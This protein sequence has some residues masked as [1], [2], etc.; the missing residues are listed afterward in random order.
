[1]KKQIVDFL[2]EFEISFNLNFSRI[3]CL[4][5]FKFQFLE[6]LT[7]AQKIGYIGG[8]Q[9]DPE[10][11]ILSNLG[12]SKIIS[13]GNTSTSEIFMD[14]ELANTISQDFDLLI[15]CN[16]IEHIWNQENFFSNLNQLTTENG[17]L[18]MVAP[19]SDFFHLSP[20]F[21]SAGFSPE[22]LR[23]MLQ[24]NG[25]SI[26][27]LQLIGSKRLYRFTHLLQE[28]PNFKQYYNP[29]F[30]HLS[31][32]R[33][34]RFKINVDYLKDFVFKILLI[35]SDKS[36]NSDPKFGHTICLLAKKI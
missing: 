23:N 29:I 20:N 27:N 10:L 5:N 13:I 33:R 24:L 34:N 16:V 25:Y 19:Y 3:L 28:W 9:I 36:I 4:M 35:F 26:I 12:K 6:N 31:K 1:M 22:Y 14:L 21:Y 15:C 8:E 7:N 32:L 2:E 18:W 11:T 17:Y 30:D